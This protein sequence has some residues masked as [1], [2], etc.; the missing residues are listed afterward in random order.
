MEVFKKI[1]Y[2]LL[3]ALLTGA[4][5]MFGKFDLPMQFLIYFLVIDYVTGMF[6]AWTTGTL[7]S[8]RGVQGIIKKVGYLILVSIAYCASELIMQSDVLKYFV[9]YVIIGNEG[10]SILE[11]LAKIGVVIPK[12]L[13]EKFEQLKIKGLDMVE[14]KNEIH[15]EENNKD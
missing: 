13:A 5:F 7:D 1:Y 3:P 2:A 10:M 12:G 11:N 8:R 15:T 9:I 6:K 4:T 14:V